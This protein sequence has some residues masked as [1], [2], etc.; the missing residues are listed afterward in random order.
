MKDDEED[1]YLSSQIEELQKE[2]QIKELQKKVR[3]AE[4]EL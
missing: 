1:I 3:E 4:G 2:A